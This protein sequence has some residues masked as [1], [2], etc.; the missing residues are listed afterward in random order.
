M[1][2]YLTEEH[3]VLRKEVRR[4]SE[5]EISPIAK[6]IDIEN[7]YPR[8][9]IRKLGELGYLGMLIPMEY[10]GSEMDMIGYCIV[11][12]EI[13]R[14]SPSLAIF[15]EVQNSLVGEIIFKYGTEDQKKRYL[16]RLSSGE[17]TGAFAL[18]EPGAGSDAA[19]ISTRAI[20][21]SNGYVINGSKLWITNGAYADFIILFA[22]TG[23][24]EERHKGISAFIIDKDT[25]GF[26]V[27]NTLDMMGIR[28]TG[29]SELVFEDVN[30]PSTALLGKEGKGFYI[31]MDAL[32]SGRIGVAAI[33]IGLA[34]RAFEE[35]LK[36]AIQR[37]AFGKRIIDFQAIGFTLADLATEI[38]AAR[39]LTYQAAYL[40]NR[41]LNYAKE[42]AMAKLFASEIAVRAADRA[43]QIHGAFGYSKES[44]VETLFRD[45]KLMVIGEGTSEIQKLVIY[46]RL[47][48]EYMS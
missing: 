28:G 14:C 2:P 11:L 24:P 8:D 6:K 32:N 23:K 36:Y 4:F 17:I 15:T 40:K 45:A 27:A 46:K 44:M 31:A 29:T 19:A 43:V 21:E 47:L 10:G 7:Y 5:E 18:S 33:S 20:K 22:R 34:Q 39:L 37:E 1:N 25:P 16:P 3:I 12:E 13:A 42:A 30:V 26:K 41:G 48:Q 9:L 38:E 35:S